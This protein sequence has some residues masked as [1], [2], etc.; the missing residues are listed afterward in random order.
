MIQS[1]CFPFCRAAPPCQLHYFPS[2]C[3]C[4]VDM[5]PAG[6]E[7]QSAQVVKASAAPAKASKS[8]A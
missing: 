5:T 4:T 7:E 3:V 2:P 8:A 1:Q 6:I